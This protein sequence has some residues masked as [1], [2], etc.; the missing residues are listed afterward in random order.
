MMPA[1]VTI[2]IYEPSLLALKSG[3]MEKKNLKY[4]VIPPV[5][6]NKVLD[7][8][9]FTLLQDSRFQKAMF[10]FFRRH[11]VSPII[12]GGGHLAL[13][14]SKLVQCRWGR[15]IE[16]FCNMSAKDLDRSIYFLHLVPSCLF[17]PRQTNLV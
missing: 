6:E 7:T 2:H 3:S 16:S 4:A 10:K 15:N 8:S 17:I 12:N 11:P 9:Q 5:P 1:L 13:F 14:S